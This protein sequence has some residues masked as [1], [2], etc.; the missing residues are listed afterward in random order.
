M[1]ISKAKFYFPNGE[2]KESEIIK[3]SYNFQEIFHNGLKAA[4][5]SCSF[6]IPFN[7]EI[8]NLFQSEINLGK[9]KIE[10]KDKDGIN[11]NTYYCKDTLQIEKT[12][13][14]QPISIQAISPSFFIDETLK[15]TVVMLGKTV[16][17]IIK[18][19]LKEI[20]FVDVRT[21]PI[22]NR[23][24]YFTANEGD[25][26]K[27]IITELLFE[28]G[29]VSYFDSDGFFNA[30]SLFDEM[31][32]DTALITQAFDGT[33]LR[34]KVI[35]KAKTHEADY[36]AASYNKVEY[37]TNTLIFSDTQNADKN[38]KCKTEIKPYY[39]IFESTE[40]RDERLKNNTGWKE[41]YCEYD[42]TNG[43]VLYVSGITPDVY[44]DKG[45]EYSISRFDKDGNDLIDKCCLKAYNG[46]NETLC[47][48]KLDI[49][50]NAW[51]AT[52]L[53]TVV[54]SKGTKQKEFDLKYIQNKQ[55]AE[56][57]ALN[58]ANYYR[59]SNF[60]ITAKSY[61]DYDL[62]SYVKITDYGIGTYY[63]RITQK[64]RTLKNDCIEYQ[65]ETI[66][67]YTP[68]EIEKTKNTRNGTN[69]A[70][71]IKGDKGDKGDPGQDGSSLFV[72]LEQSSA[73]FNV[74]DIGKVEE[75]EV[76]IPIHVI[77]DGVELPFKI[78]TL[79]KIDGLTI[80]EYINEESHGIRVRTT[81]DYLLENGTFDIPII[82]TEVTHAYIY[83]DR[84]KN[85]AIGLR[86]SG[87]GFGSFTLDETSITDYN[88][89]FTYSTAR[90]A[91][92]RGAKN[93]IDGF[94]DPNTD[95]NL[96]RGDWFTWT[97]EEISETYN[98]VKVTFKTAKVYKW[99]GSYWEE[100]SN[101]E[102][103]MTAF[104]DV[105]SV[106]GQKL[107]LNNGYIKDL[108]ERL[109][110]NDA[111]LDRLNNDVMAQLLA[112]NTKLQETLATQT[113]FL[114]TLNNDVM[115]ELLAENTKLQETLASQTKFLNAL[116]NDVMADLLAKNTKLQET[117]ATQTKFLNTLNN[118]TLGEL[119]A[120]NETLDK[121]LAEKDTF[122]EA[123]NSN[124]EFTDLLATN[125]ALIKK[126][127]ANKAYI[128]ELTADKTFTD[129]LVSNKVYTDALAANT[130]F[131]DSLIAN[132][133]YTDALAASSAFI[134]SLV[135]NK[136]Y[137]DSLAANTA[138]ADKLIAN[139]TFTE[140]LAANETF[141][142]KLVA[143]ETYTDSLA[144]NT[145][146]ADKLIANQTFTESLAANE[147]F[148]NKLVANETYTK[149]LA[150]N[151]TFTDS[152]AANKAYLEELTAN[153]TFTNLLI[154]NESFIKLLTSDS[155]FIDQIVGNQAFIKNLV[156]QNS[157]INNLL[158]AKLTIKDGGFIQSQ[159]YESS[160]GTQGFRISSD[161]TVV[162]KNGTFDN[163]NSTGAK[164]VNGSYSGTL[165]CGPL[166]VKQA[167]FVSSKKE[168]SAGNYPEDYN[169][170]VAKYYCSLFGITPET[171]S[172]SGSKS[173]TSI[174]GNSDAHAFA[175]D[176]EIFSLK[177]E[178]Y[179]LNNRA[180]SI[181]L[182][183]WGI[184]GKGNEILIYEHGLSGSIAVFWGPSPIQHCN[185]K[186]YVSAG[187]K[188]MLYL[189]ELPTAK[190]DGAGYA[191][192]N[193]GDLCIS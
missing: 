27:D 33:N 3:D 131:A 72:Y 12:Q 177:I 8:S 20:E 76:E 142:N 157:F 192:N 172:Y 2:E 93:K 43:K 66:T 156:S 174:Y 166:K 22:Y 34:E 81:K 7:V 52:E 171:Y 78:G 48:R 55:D 19:L 4:D 41:N 127:I 32:E 143:N 37:F 11:I 109:A 87:I 136:T 149:S 85:Y 176:T 42:S 102:H 104:S 75:A 17:E 116:N 187:D 6:K 49:Y 158:S 30:R 59:F 70:T 144:A 145:A 13:K 168:I 1:N 121:K 167:S 9:V 107:E 62:G 122:F 188:L 53:N 95:F 181:Y 18:A 38:N 169:N 100:D 118:E 90:L 23:L 83:G 16:A 186:A 185:Y 190:P 89:V 63:G 152:L 184:D 106:A 105:L 36:V 189:G 64:K 114:N 56:N 140:S 180:T 91:L 129:S 151:E 74:D 108:L 133:T 50:G 178:N 51:I 150:A 73:V 44:F 125:T 139:Q 29:Y 115:A 153:T 110:T 147:T 54:S 21:I 146:F 25:K 128:E 160:G 82:Y 173:I 39:C 14:N 67:D 84:S 124:T 46:T 111:F 96:H 80:E 58:V 47:C 88:L 45:I 77:C 161:G 35:I 120:N 159:N 69:A 68:A 141:S 130:A 119:L 123:L 31:P 138:F 193:N 132:K 5:G 97:G 99:N 60:E 40:E 165:D 15:R 134:D 98:G 164:F 101:L 154:A 92:Y 28:Y 61:V 10:I 113:K 86:N 170:S 71:A 182:Q 155:A 94:L 191:W 24:N 135:S 103:Q 26:V 175:G 163:I 117:L 65:I 137:T 126:L 183:V 162:F 148:S 179:Y 112:E 79:E 57:F